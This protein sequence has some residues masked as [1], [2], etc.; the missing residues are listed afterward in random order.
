MYKPREAGINKNVYRFAETE[1]E[2]GKSILDW[3]N[4]TFADLIKVFKYAQAPTSFLADSSSNATSF[5]K[6]NKDQVGKKNKLYASEG[7]NVRTN[8]GNRNVFNFNYM[9]LKVNVRE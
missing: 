2:E 9:T 1:Y 5:E 6:V 3:V 7:T 4:E 8:A